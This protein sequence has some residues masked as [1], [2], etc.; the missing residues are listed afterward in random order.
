[1]FLKHII[2]SVMS[3]W[4]TCLPTHYHVIHSSFSRIAARNVPWIH[5]V[6]SFFL[7]LSILL[8]LRFAQQMITQHSIFL[9]TRLSYKYSQSE[10]LII[11]FKV[12]GRALAVLLHLL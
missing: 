1:M 7:I 8:T 12:F 6:L 2:V 5:H 10:I 3:M 4:T 11:S 9:F